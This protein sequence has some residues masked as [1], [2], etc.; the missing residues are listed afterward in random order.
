MQCTK[1]FAWEYIYIYIYIGFDFSLMLLSIW[2]DMI[3]I[4]VLKWTYVNFVFCLALLF[5]RV[6]NMWGWRPKSSIGPLALAEDMSYPRRN[7]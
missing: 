3:V 7:K 6:Y 1:K 2:G 4:C 5:T